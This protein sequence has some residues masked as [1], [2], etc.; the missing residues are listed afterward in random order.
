MYCFEASV[1]LVLTC[2]CS[3]EIERVHIKSKL[4][5]DDV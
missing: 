2:L 1:Q 3:Q 4:S 5:E